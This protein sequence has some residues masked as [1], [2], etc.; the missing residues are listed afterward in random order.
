[1][2]YRDSRIFSSPFCVFG[3]GGVL[4]KNFASDLVLKSMKLIRLLEGDLFMKRIEYRQGD[5]LLTKVR[6]VPSENRRGAH[7]YP[8]DSKVVAEG[9]ATGHSHQLV[10]EAGLF[11]GWHVA[12]FVH[13]TGPAQLVHEEHGAIGLEPGVYAITIQREYVPGRQSRFVRD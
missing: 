1:M 9:E 3:Y 4:K 7:V 5:V 10:G 2:H 13:V 8:L 11:G 6:Q 12:E